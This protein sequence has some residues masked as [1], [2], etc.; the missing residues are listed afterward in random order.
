MCLHLQLAS[1]NL[2]QK[3]QAVRCIKNALQGGG[4]STKSVDAAVLE[5]AWEGLRQIEAEDGSS[6]AEVAA[7]REKLQCVV[8]N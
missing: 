7:W 6:S 4:G 8:T 1:S 2:Q 5:A 3:L